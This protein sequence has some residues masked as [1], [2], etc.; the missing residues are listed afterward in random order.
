MTDSRA[1][2]EYTLGTLGR[3]TAASQDIGHPYQLRKGFCS[4][5]L[6]EIATM[7][8][9]RNLG[10]ADFG[11]DLFIHEPA[12]YERHH[13]LLTWRQSFKFRTQAGNR[14]LALMPN[15]VA[16]NRNLNRI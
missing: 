10:Y 13:L 14:L 2:A 16:L 3:C 7:H 5:F 6:C 12:C 1:P 9:H 15:P 4:H 11:G 8:V